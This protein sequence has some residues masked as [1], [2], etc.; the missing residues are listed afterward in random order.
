MKCEKCGKEHD[1]SYGSGRFCSVICAKSRIQTNEIREKKS[2]K[3]TINK[4]VYCKYCGGKLYRKGNKYNACRKCIYEHNLFHPIVKEETRKKL[5]VSAI[6]HNLGGNTSKIKLRF[7]KKNG[8]EVWLQSS[9]EIKFA[10]ILENLNLEWERPKP[11]EWI[12]NNNKKHRYYPDF[13][14]GNSY[15]DTK[16]DYLAEKDKDKIQKV[17]EQ[18]NIQVLIVTKENINEEFILKHI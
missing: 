4:P 17:N 1:G 11:F 10:N 18:N 8:T 9:Y 2:L 6:K 15:F 3:L 14:V 13:K 12:D 16:N 5:S 7:K